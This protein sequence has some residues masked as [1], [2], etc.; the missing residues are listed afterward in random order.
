VADWKEW[1]AECQ[2]FSQ[3]VDSW[4]V[5]DNLGPNQW[6]VKPPISEDVA[7]H[8]ERMMG[9][10]FPLELREFYL[11]GS[12]GINYYWY[13]NPPEEYQ[14][15]V[16]AIF[17]ED[18][19]SGGPTIIDAHSQIEHHNRA[20]EVLGDWLRHRKPSAEERA[21]A[22]N[23]FPLIEVRNGDEVFLHVPESGLGGKVYCYNHEF[24]ASESPLIEMSETFEAFMFAWRHLYYVGPEGWMFTPFM[25]FEDG[26]YCR[27]NMTLPNVA[28]WRDLVARLQATCECG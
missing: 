6:E 4:P 7:V 22:E 18:G 21:V 25:D 23:L 11:T 26:S 27:L 16:R 2:R 10:S 15:T 13:W 19:V 12:G 8:I 20:A 5:A 17:G 28:K 24:G 9:R 1:V 14:E 3:N